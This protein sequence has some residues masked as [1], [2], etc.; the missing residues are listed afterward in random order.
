[1]DFYILTEAEDK[2]CIK[3]VEYFHANSE[4]KEWKKILDSIKKDLKKV[5]KS[6]FGFDVTRKRKAQ[7][8]IDNWK[9]LLILY[10]YFD[11]NWIAPINNPNDRAQFKIGFQQVNQQVFAADKA[12]TNINDNR[13]SRVTTPERQIYSSERISNDHDEEIKHENDDSLNLLKQSKKYLQMT[14]MWKQHMKT[15]IIPS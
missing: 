5:I 8:I 10:L 7:R 3:V 6:T 12:I 14:K 13:T 11:D 9:I 15:M 2:T 1:M 4:H